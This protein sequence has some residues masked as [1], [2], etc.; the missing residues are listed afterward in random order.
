[1]FCL[2][3]VVPNSNNKLS[4]LVSLVLWQLLW[5][6]VNSEVHSMVLED[7]K[8]ENNPGK[9]TAKISNY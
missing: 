8:N 4:A 5:W 7:L 9:V 1:M 6:C 2:T 3:I